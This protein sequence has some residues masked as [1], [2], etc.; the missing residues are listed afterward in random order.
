MRNPCAVCTWLALVYH[1]SL[2]TVI[3]SKCLFVCITLASNR[4]LEGLTHSQRWKGCN[5]EHMLREVPNVFEMV[6]NI[7]GL[8]WNTTLLSMQYFKLCAL[9]CGPL[10][11]VSFNLGI[12][13]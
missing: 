8:G 12:S 11:V 6:K 4:V 13:L 1:N 3:L 9:H 5:Y 10:Y 7:R 2:S